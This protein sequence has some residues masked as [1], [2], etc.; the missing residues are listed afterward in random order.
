MT[1]ASILAVLSL[2][3]NTSFADFPRL[4]RLIAE[5]DYLP[6]AFANR[7]RR[8]VYS[9]GIGILTAFSAALLVAFGGI[10]DRLIPLFAIG[11][12]GAFTLS[13]AGMT[14]HWQRHPGETPAERAKARTSRVINAAGAVATALVLAVVLATKFAAGAWLTLLIIPGVFLLFERVK[15]HYD[16]VA[17]ETDCPRPMDLRQRQP[18]VVVIPMKG[19]TTITENA[20]RFGLDISP[21]V[22]AIHISTDEADA[23]H[24]QDSWRQYVM[25]PIRAA[26]L[27]EPHLMVL[28]S[29]YRRLFNPM[30]DYLH[31]LKAA[32]PG[33]MIAVIIPELV[34]SH[35]YQYFLHNQRAAALKA[36]LLLRGGPRVTVINVPWYLTD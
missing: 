36:A 31:Q 30:M 3:A 17:R 15:N 12:F 18:P 13:Q 28:L 7:G 34:E 27:T 6:H 24:L 16:H 35:W 21:D 8:L 26:E 29:P 14:V 1:L 20:L 4:C 32:Y 5:D 11:A 22:V 33:R 2:S 23:H 10:T 25:A 9:L 19:W